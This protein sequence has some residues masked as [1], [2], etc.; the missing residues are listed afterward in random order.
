[1]VG[2]SPN[3]PRQITQTMPTYLLLW[4]SWAGGSSVT[5]FRIT[6]GGLC[7]SECSWLFILVNHQDINT[8]YLSRW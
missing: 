2:D 1:M 3:Q 7:C 5:L 6:N 4:V 8:S